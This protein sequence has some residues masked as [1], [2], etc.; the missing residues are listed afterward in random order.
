M[1]G[2]KTKSYYSDLLPVLVVSNSLSEQQWVL[3]VTYNS[4]LYI[5]NVKEMG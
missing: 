5:P 2:F 4:N 3:N 1:C